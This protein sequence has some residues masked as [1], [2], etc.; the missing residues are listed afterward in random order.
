LVL[1]TR[2]Q[3]EA[4]RWVAGLRT[5][6]L[7]AQ[8]LPLIVI[9][10][11][12]DLLPLHQAALRLGEFAAVMFV[13]GNAVSYFWAQLPAG[14]QQD[15]VQGRFMT[16][17]WSP[18]PG[19]T[20][21]LRQAGLA[22]SQID[23]PAETAPQFDSEAL[24]ARVAAQVRP[25]QRVLIVRGSDAQGQGAGRDWLAEQLDAAGVMVERL[26]AYR[27]LPPDWTAP[28]LAQ[29]QQ[30]ATDGAV[31]LFSSSEAIDNLTAQLP[32]QSWQAARAVVTHARIAATARRAG[33]GVV[34]EARPTLAAVAA[35]IKSCK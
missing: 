19:T 18:G 22:L 24:W 21:A 14:V 16:R 13:S 27:R 34:W 33:W 4:Q 29:A 1:V 9:A 5:L 35:S 10:P 7:N 15:W 26:G 20:L 6:G 30:A 8:A 25:G 28:A 2:P 17:A 3:A 12:L 32:G 23:T 11:V 31:W